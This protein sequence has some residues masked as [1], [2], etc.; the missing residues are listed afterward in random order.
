M[1]LDAQGRPI[2]VSKGHAKRLGLDEN[3]KV[4]EGPVEVKH[5]NDRVVADGYCLHCKSR[6]H[7]EVRLSKRDAR[8]RDADA[9]F[10]KNLEDLACERVQRDHQCG[11]IYEGRDTL[12]DLYRRLGA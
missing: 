5:Y 6:V 11:L 2:D 12:E 10:S 7:H 1:L 8:A 3:L 9:Q 4:F